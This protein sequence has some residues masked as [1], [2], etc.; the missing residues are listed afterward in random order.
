VRT[1]TAHVLLMD[2][3]PDV[4]KLTVGAAFTISTPRCQ[5]FPA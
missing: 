3:D 1:Q 5:G 2:D 4:F